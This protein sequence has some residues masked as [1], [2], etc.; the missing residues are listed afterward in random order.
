[1][2]CYAGTIEVETLKLFEQWSSNVGKSQDS[3]AV[4]EFRTWNLSILLSG[5]SIIT[6]TQVNMISNLACK[7]MDFTL[8]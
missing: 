2:H 1:M 4:Q 3:A 5:A 7:C 6:V 8:A